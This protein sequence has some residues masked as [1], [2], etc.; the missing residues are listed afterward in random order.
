MPGISRIETVTVAVG[1]QEIALRWFIDKLGFEKRS[2][3]SGPGFRWLTV[4]PKGQNG[5]EIL[6][7]SWF[8]ESVGKNAMWVL[9]TPDCRRTYE[10]LK[11]RGVTFRETPEDRGSRVEAVFQD[12]YGNEYELVEQ[13][14]RRIR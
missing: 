14:T 13:K 12:L 1:D 11:G 4:A 8:P 10:D 5:V 6:L 9:A 3:M 7:A 2:D